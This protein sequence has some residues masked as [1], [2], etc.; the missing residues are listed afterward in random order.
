MLTRRTVL[1]TAAGATL[2][3]A[4]SGLP[5]KAKITSSVMLWT[6]RGSFEERVEI[7]AKAGMQSVELVAEHVNW[8]RRGCSR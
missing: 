8:T 6:L 4:Q 7:A 2:A 5:K 1:Q 3:S